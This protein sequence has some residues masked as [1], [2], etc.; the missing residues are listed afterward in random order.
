MNIDIKASPSEISSRTFVLDTEFDLGL[1]DEA[2]NSLS[3]DQ[4][5]NRVQDFLD[6]IY[7]Q[8]YWSLDSYNE[9]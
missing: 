1:T 3:P 9:R 5:G 4:Q 6:N 8:P 7:E 2:W